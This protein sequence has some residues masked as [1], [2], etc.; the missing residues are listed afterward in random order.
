V[1]NFWRQ[2]LAG[3]APETDLGWNGASDESYALAEQTFAIDAGLCRRLREFSAQHKVTVCSLFQIAWGVVLTRYRGSADVIFGNVVSGRSAGCPGIDRAV[4]CFI[5]TL[6][7]R[8][9][10][11]AHDTVLAAARHRHEDAQTCEAMGI[12][13]LAEIQECAGRAAERLIDHWFVFEN[14]PVEQSSDRIRAVNGGL[15]LT[16]LRSSDAANNYMNVIVADRPLYTVR[17]KYNANAL[18]ADYVAQLGRHYARAIAEVAADPERP[19]REIDL[20][21]EEEKETLLA[22]F[23]RE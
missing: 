1:R 14:Y 16:G 10:P 2:Y 13:G 18:A 21:T 23:S 12:L 4:G 19:L 3:H 15:H 7:V 5:N 9:V 6:P 22:E 8:F 20:V 11:A 17:I